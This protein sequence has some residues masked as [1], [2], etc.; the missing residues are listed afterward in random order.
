MEEQEQPKEDQAQ[1]EER[2]KKSTSIRSFP[3]KNLISIDSFRMKG[4]E[5]CFRI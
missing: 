3:G 1:P 4:R 2:E 5:S